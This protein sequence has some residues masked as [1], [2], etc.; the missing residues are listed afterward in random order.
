MTLWRKAQWVIIFSALSA[1]TIF[2]VGDVGITHAE[3]YDGFIDHNVSRL[4]DGAKVYFADSEGHFGRQQYV[5]SITPAQLSDLEGS[6]TVTTKTYHVGH[7]TYTVAIVNVKKGQDTKGIKQIVGKRLA[8]DCK[9]QT[10]HSILY[11][12]T[13]P[14]LS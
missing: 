2:A 5:C 9:V 10:N 14:E 11:I 12:F 7:H 6:Y 3:G 8:Q 4:H 1:F 13:V